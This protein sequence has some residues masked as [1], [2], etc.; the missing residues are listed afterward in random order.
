VVLL[1]D[2]VVN[3]ELIIQKILG[4]ITIFDALS[5][6]KISNFLYRYDIPF[7][8]RILTLLNLVIFN[9]Y[10]PYSAKIGTNCV[11]GY[12]GLSIVIHPRSQIGEHVVIS[13]CVTIGGRSKIKSVPIIGNNVLIG[14]GAKILGNVSVGDNC[15]IGA[16]AVVITDVPNNCVVAG[17]PGKIIKS[18]I[19]I[20]DYI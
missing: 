17:I 5:I 2:K 11:V 19:N 15:V 7:I 13:Q 3:A 12:G 6:Y 18:Q 16:N 8:P 10:I 9:A 4:G 1:I 20:N 14:A